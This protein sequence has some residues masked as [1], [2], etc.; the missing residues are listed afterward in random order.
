MQ[1]SR[2]DV[3]YILINTY[4]TSEV[5]SLQMILNEI[6][7]PKIQK[8]SSG[9]PS[10][11]Q[12]EVLIPSKMLVNEIFN[13]EL[14]RH[15]LKIEESVRAIRDV[16][17]ERGFLNQEELETVI[18]RLNIDQDK[19]E[20]SLDLLVGYEGKFVTYSEAIEVIEKIKKAKPKRTVDRPK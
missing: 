10:Y 4:K 12:D 9:D 7:V 11:Y 20:A 19:I 15:L 6:L 1:L 16:D 8:Y 5:D 14:S 18:T 3:Q 2:K 13:Y 17:K